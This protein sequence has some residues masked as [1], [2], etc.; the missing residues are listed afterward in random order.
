MKQRPSKHR[1]GT[2]ARRPRRK[3]E[4]PWARWSDE[5]LLDLPLKNLR[6][7]LPRS[8]IGRYLDRLGRELAL[9]GI[10]FRPHVWLSDEWFS[11]D[12]VPGFAI[13]FYLAHPRL[14]R[15][16][17]K[18]MQEV[19]GGNA[20]WLMRIL[21]HECGHAI[22]TAYRLRRHREWRAVFGKASRRYPTSYR[23]QP[24][25][26]RFVLHLGHWYA[27]SH[28]TED[29]A[30]TFAVW[31]QPRS[32]WRREYAE[33]PALRKLQYVDRAMKTLRA[34]RPIVKAR[35]EIEPLR[36]NGRTLREHYRRERARFA[37]EISKTYDKELL[38][39]FKRRSEGTR[40][41]AASQIVRESRPQLLRLMRRH[42]GMHPYLIHNV[43]RTIIE[44]CR[45]LDLIAVQSR[46]ASKRAALRL[47][48]RIVFDMIHRRRHKY[49]L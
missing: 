43:V 12:G 48:E 21:R 16:E 5:R 28:P 18:M 6:L 42:A 31:L 9:R 34:T 33:W 1:K 8:T 32:T 29:F 37:V 3:R 26:K 23:P 27:Q 4:P 7:S 10:S 41:V 46:R 15:L 19:E 25:S 17:R 30:E 13:P 2:P 49:V 11:P 38:R 39:A 47:M 44:R 35:D 45:E 22:D 36:E 24:A 20:N 40:A 14:M